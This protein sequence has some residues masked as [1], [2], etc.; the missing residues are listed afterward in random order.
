VRALSQLGYLVDVAHDGLEALD[1][2]QQH[3]YAMI[4]MD[5]HMPQMDGLEATRRIRSLSDPKS[6]VPI[7]ALTASVL[8]EEQQIY[9]DAGMNDFLG[10][11]FSV[12]Q[13]RAAV[14]QWSTSSSRA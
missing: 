9:L 7:V 2:V 5:V 8:S 6:D 4:L 10:K 1:L 13:L 14:Q 3:D 12:E 11:P